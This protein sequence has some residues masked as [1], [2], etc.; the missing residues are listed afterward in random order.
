MFGVIGWL[1]RRFS[2]SNAQSQIQARDLELLN[3]AADDLN[4]EATDVIDFQTANGKS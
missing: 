4:A 1:L 3:Q 2:R